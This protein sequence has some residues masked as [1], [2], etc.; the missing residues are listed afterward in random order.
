MPDARN[1]GER[2][3]PDYRHWPTLP[4]M[5]FDRAAAG[6]GRPFLWHKVDG[7][8]ASLDWTEVAEQVARIAAALHAA[9]VEAG[10]RVVLVSEN[11]PE[12]LAADVAIMAVGAIA[13]PTYTTNTVEDHRH[14][15]ADCGAR[16]AIASTAELADRV[17]EAATG[18]PGLRHLIAIEAPTV[19]AGHVTVSGWPDG[20]APA[21]GMTELV[22]KARQG[23]RGAAACII[24]TSGTG[25]RPKGVVLSH[26]NI[27]ANC[28][29]AWRRLVDVCGLED[30]VFLS[31]LP[32]SHSY[33]HTCGQFF[34][35]SIGAQIY[36]AEGIEQLG[37][38]LT[39][40]RPTLMTAVPRL[41][42]GMHSRITR[43]VERAGGLKAALFRR[44]VEIGSKRYHGKALSLGERLLDPLLE[45]L[46]RD[47]V[48]A[49]FGG[50]LKGL[51]SGGAPLNIDV[52]V[53]FHA[54]GLRLSQGYGQTEAAP[55]IS[56]NPLERIKL[57]TVGLPVPGVEVRIAEDGEILA[58][59]DMV[60]LGYWN[61]PEATAETL[62]DGWLHTGDIGRIDEDGY[63]EI[64]DRKKDIIVN[65]GGD[66]L[67]PSRI[68][69][70]LT[71]EPEIH[72][73]LVFGD[74]KPHLVALIVPDAELARE[75]TDPDRLRARVRTAVER[76]NARLSAIE[77]VRRFALADE[78]FSVDTG[79]L[80]P[81]MKTRRHAVLH[82]YG[83][84]LLHLYE[85]PG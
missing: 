26:A 13:V 61:K 46:V 56:C 47:K 71:L 68:E 76:V 31:F 44:A 27:F 48:R 42:E 8:Y 74:R 19:P 12:F 45:R 75:E 36:Y 81:T 10:D 40:A 3:M 73:A 55:L 82:R 85:R 17:L 16:A 5:F 53:F 41:Y 18:A 39:E 65:S 38:N 58:R 57:H 60:M 64:T 79:E 35:I 70:F 21:A 49:R 28:E 62:R 4:A 54:L 80:T 25:G 23:E 52:G 84:K 24:Y 32:L 6:G 50:R 43:D 69:G 14:I 22:A 30:E 51:V 7:R 29:G 15:L 33:E 34:P 59:G 83:Q 20:A 37:R 1:A 67:S 2:R 63:L 11:R 66:N 9:G 77:R 78:P 72:Q